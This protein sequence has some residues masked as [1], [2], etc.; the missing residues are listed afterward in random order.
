MFL[1]EINKMKD[2]DILES[3]SLYNQQRNKA[4]AYIL[5]IL[6]EVIRRKLHLKEGY[7]TLFDFVLKELHIDEGSVYNFTK[8]ADKVAKYPMAL[9]MIYRGELH[10]SGLKVS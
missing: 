3:L 5:A 8:A 7:S 6:A 9:A 1:D 4:T 10:L 2:Q